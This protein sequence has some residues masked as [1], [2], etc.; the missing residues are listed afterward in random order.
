M[1]SVGKSK[2]PIDIILNRPLGLIGCFISAKYQ[3][4]AVKHVQKMWETDRQTHRQ[5]DRQTDTQ[6]DTQTHRQTLPKIL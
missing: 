2:C 3:N 4:R 1:T 6:T 5:T